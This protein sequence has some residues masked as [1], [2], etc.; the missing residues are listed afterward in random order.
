[1]T[2]EAFTALADQGYNRIPVVCEVLADLDTPLSVYLKLAEGPYSYLFES[3]HGGEKWGRYSI[4]G[5]PCHT[6]LRVHGQHVLVETDGR[7][8]EDLE[9]ADPLAWIEAFQARYGS[10]ISVAGHRPDPLSPQ[11][12]NLFGDGLRNG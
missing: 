2:P 12:V 4:I 6:R 9:V 10:E 8:V 1:M 5:L 11:S 7:V 3:V